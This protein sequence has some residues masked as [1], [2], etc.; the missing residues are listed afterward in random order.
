MMLMKILW[1]VDKQMILIWPKLTIVSCSPIHGIRP[2]GHVQAT[3][4]H[5]NVPTAEKSDFDKTEKSDF[6]KG[7]KSDFEKKYLSKPASPI[8]TASLNTLSTQGS[9]S[10]V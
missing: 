10:T 1:Y 7:E 2:H 6:D 5:P 4:P 9:Q 8:D 3:A